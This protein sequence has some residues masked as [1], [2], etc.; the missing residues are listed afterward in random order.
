MTA[1]DHLTELDD[2]VI[3]TDRSSSPDELALASAQM[4][5]AQ[6]AVTTHDADQRLE[7][8]GQQLGELYDL[9]QSGSH[10]RGMELAAAAWGE[11]QALHAHVR[12]LTEHHVALVT[13]ATRIWGDFRRLMVEHEDLVDALVTT[14]T[15]HPL[16]SSAYEGIAEAAYHD[17]QAALRDDRDRLKETAYNDGYSDAANEHQAPTDFIDR[18]A[19][20]LGCGWPLAQRICAGLSGDVSLDDRTIDELLQ[21]L[22]ELQRQNGY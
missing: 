17:A 12:A 14:D 3:A 5:A 16:V 4:Q 22:Y 8:I 19:D 10:Q 18:V 2:M 20:A 15:D 1:L 11:T 21:I 6:L 7:A 13:L 9:A